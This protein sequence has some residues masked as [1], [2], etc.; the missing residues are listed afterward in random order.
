MAK[1]RKPVKTQ[2]LQIYVYR[3]AIQHHGIVTHVPEE[4]VVLALS[5]DE[6]PVAVKV[7]HFDSGCDGVETTSL[8]IFLQVCVVLSC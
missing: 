7:V 5:E 1:T 8:E 4:A 2:N 6:L 3:G